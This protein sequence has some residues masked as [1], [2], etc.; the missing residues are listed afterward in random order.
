MATTALAVIETIQ[1]IDLFKPE[2][3]RPKLGSVR[4][5]YIEQASALDISTPENRKAI[6]SLAYEIGQSKNFVDK[7]RIALVSDQKKALKLIDAQGSENWDYLEALQKEVRKPLTDWEQ[8]DKDRI[9]AHEAELAE[10]A[11][12]GQWSY[13]NWQ[14]LSVEA[15]QDRLAEIEGDKRDWQEFASRAKNSILIATVAIQ[16]AI[17]KRKAFDMERAELERLRAESA[18]REQ[19]EREERIARDATERAERQ[20]AERE[21]SAKRAA[22][23]AERAAKDREAQSAREAADAVARHQREQEAAQARVARAEQDAKDAQARAARISEDAKAAEL[24]EQKQL[25]KDKAHK[26]EVHNAAM[27]AFIKFGMPEDV[28]KDII[29]VIAKGKIPGVKVV[30]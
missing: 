3:I 23:D 13:Q 24:A 7:Q 11:Q 29:I 22:E 19:Q 12:A 1:A 2:I 5:H 10:I 8:L 17:S 21:A 27:Q 15:M 20:A 26:A 30:Y 18:A 4:A 25:A 9:A 16:D 14:T 6:A 28:A